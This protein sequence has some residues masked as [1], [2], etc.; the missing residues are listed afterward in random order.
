MA[1]RMHPQDLRAIVAAI[2]AST[3]NKIDHFTVALQEADALLVELERTAKPE[4]QEWPKEALERI[5]W[6]TDRCAHHEGRA[7]DAEARVKVLEEGAILQ[8]EAFE[9]ARSAAED[10][11]ARAEG[12]ESALA[13]AEQAIN[14]ERANTE[15]AEAQLSEAKADAGRWYLMGQNIT[16]LDFITPERV[17]EETFQKLHELRSKVSEAKAEVAEMKVSL[18]VRTEALD[19]VC[20]ERDAAARGESEAVQRLAAIDAAKVGEPPK[21]KWPSDGCCRSHPHEP[22]PG[23]CDGSVWRSI[24][25]H[26]RYTTD[27]EAWGRMGW[28]AAAS[29]RK[30]DVDAVY[31]ATLAERDRIIELLIQTDEAAVCSWDVLKR[32]PEFGLWDAPRLRTFLEPKP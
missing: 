15:K 17:Q 29:L 28:D 31:S 19:Q 7:D 4:P 22:E 18:D 24:E 8:R 10:F 2:C 26:R 12:A 23:V 25:K 11:R 32:Q 13:M 20:R 3:D 30:V 5:E 9:L 27:L 16:G 6:W 14:N 21:P 1:E